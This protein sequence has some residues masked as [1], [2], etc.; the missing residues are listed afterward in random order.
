MG[1]GNCQAIRISISERAS[2]LSVADLHRVCGAAVAGGDP[3]GVGAVHDAVAAEGR[4]VLP[5][6]PVGHGD[7]AWWDVA[8]EG[9]GGVPEVV[10]V[11]GASVEKDG[12]ALVD[13]GR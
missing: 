5:V 3:L 2:S 13:L 11:P 12:D 7:E 6:A 8:K 10:G 4:V 1:S 9:R